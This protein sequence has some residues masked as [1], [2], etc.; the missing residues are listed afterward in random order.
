MTT[1][2]APNRIPSLQ[3]DFRVAVATDVVNRWAIN[4]REVCLFAPGDG[5]RAGGD[6]VLLARH[7]G[8]PVRIFG[9]GLMF[10][11]GVVVDDVLCRTA[12]W[13]FCSSADFSARLTKG[14]GEAMTW[15][16]R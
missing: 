2:L 13:R 1:F 15:L 9:H 8:R 11:G 10:A 7:V 5:G 16:L 12:L 14:A 3:R 6:L 4:R